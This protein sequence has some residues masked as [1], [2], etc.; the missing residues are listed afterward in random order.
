MGINDLH[1]LQSLYSMSYPSND[2]PDDKQQLQKDIF[3]IFKMV[4]E[5]K[6]WN[7]TSPQPKAF[8]WIINDQP[9]PSNPSND[10]TGGS[11]IFQRY[12]LT[13]IYCLMTIFI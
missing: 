12:V 6:L 11:N 10:F 4:L 9:L 3:D 13:V 8:H 5:K 7:E 2:H 1:L